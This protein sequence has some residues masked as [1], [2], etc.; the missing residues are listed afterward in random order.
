MLKRLKG[1]EKQTKKAKKTDFSAKSGIYL[2]NESDEECNVEE[3]V[4][5]EV[6]QRPSHSTEQIPDSKQRLKV[7]AQ[8]RLPDFRVV[9]ILLSQCVHRHICF[10]RILVPRK[11]CNYLVP[12]CS[13]EQAG[14]SEQVGLES[15]PPSGFVSSALF[16]S[17]DFDESACF[18]LPRSWRKLSRHPRLPFC[19]SNRW[20][21]Q[22]LFQDS[23]HCMWLLSP[24]TRFL[25]HTTQQYTRFRCHSRPQTASM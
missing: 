23:I 17:R 7:S 12:W 4:E 3:V 10:K 6:G 14:Q 20:N 13:R 24:Q 18:H 1:H 25:W 5:M 2:D 15:P 19:T 9:W 11:R 8:S 21:S 16:W 22:P